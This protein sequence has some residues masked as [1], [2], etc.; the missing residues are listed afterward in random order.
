MAV[1]AVAGCGGSVAKN[2]AAPGAT[3][4]ETAQ[5]AAWRQH[6]QQFSHELDTAL[7]ALASTASSD[8]YQAVSNLGPLTYCSQNLS[9]L[10]SPPAVYQLAYGS[11]AAACE[12]FETGAREW[13]DEASSRG[14]D[15]DA[16]TY[17]IRRG[18][19]VLARGEERLQRFAD[20]QP[21]LTGAEAAR[22]QT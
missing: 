14:S 17:A 2:G 19:A 6:A 16:A 12:D 7:Q 3:R 1:I 4:H 11:V 22:A 13:R 21:P 15:F 18:S 5:E 20:Q 10:G 9:A 8:A